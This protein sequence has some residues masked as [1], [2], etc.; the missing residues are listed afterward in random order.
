MKAKTI[1]LVLTLYLILSVIFFVIRYL[2]IKDFAKSSQNSE[3]QRVKLVYKETL[4]RVKKFYITRGYANINSFGIK[5]GFANKDASSLHELSKP[6]WNI[7][8]KENIY[9][10]SFSFYDEKGN[11]L[12]YFG[13][14]PE[15]K[16]QY[17]EASKKPYAGFWYDKNSFN[18]H[19]VAEARD[20]KSN[21]IGYLVFTID[22][23]YFLSEIRK[24]MNIYTYIIYEKT[25]NK[26]I[27]F[28]LKKED[29]IAD[30]IKNQKITNHKE[31]KTKDGIFLPYI[32][33]SEGINK[34]N[35][36]KIVFLQDVMHW[37]ITIQKAILQ[38]L[39]ALLILALVTTIIINYGFDIIL[40][41]LD[42][43]NEKLKLSQSELEKLNKNLQIEVEEQIKLK[44][45]KEREANEKERILAH[46]SKLAS[47]GE[48]IGNIAHQWRQPLTEL[49]SILINLQLYFEK[50]KL[51]K[52][53]FQ[54]KAKEA[55][56]QIVFMSKTI[57][58]FRNFFAT[59]KKKEK[60]KISDI[61]NRVHNLMDGS[62]KNNNIELDIEIKDDFEIFGFP[63]EIAQA[64]LNIVSNAKDVA[65]ER[66]I[67]DA[68]IEIKSFKQERKNIITVNDNAGGIKVFPIDKIFEPY[69]STKH[70]KSGTG[71]GLYMTK[72]IIEKNN[73]GKIEIKNWE[74]GAVFTIIF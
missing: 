34:Q 28:M 22:P 32:I 9:L 45:K 59:R 3:L 18:Y 72:I 5:D 2:D 8:N 52:E 51:T 65:L 42:E 64:F 11:L 30:I 71:I 19:A 55:N 41:E 7:I 15:K 38:S 58:D 29:S 49:S 4:L 10:K 70:A 24:L 60:Y 25:D 23:K 35:N 47:M 43:S 17:F 67:E 26:K 6:R 48:M 73:N 20:K 13:K 21:I 62:L 14:K 68:K 50:D 69:F 16:L 36:F 39:I 66:K 37:K 61:I 46:Q 53:K 27:L 54:T 63:N 56:E 40:K 57:D 1:T 33:N 31:I 74:Q 12:T 44:L